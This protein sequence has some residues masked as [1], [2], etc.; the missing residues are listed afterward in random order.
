MSFKTTDP[1][2]ATPPT[3]EAYWAEVENYEWLYAR[4]LIEISPAVKSF[5]QN[6]L[7][8]YDEPC[9]IDDPNDPSGRESIE[10]P[11]GAVWRDSTIDWDEVAEDHHS[12]AASTTENQLLRIV[13]AL[14]IRGREV[15][16]VRDVG[17][18]G[19][20]RG[21]VAWILGRY[22]RNEPSIK[23]QDAVTTG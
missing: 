21:E 6:R 13:L 8:W 23:I 5:V 12:W 2:P 4:E 16:L 19:S 11:S 20:W 10:D 9:W 7:R 18:M 3:W 14:T 17:N 15:S 1:K 22:I